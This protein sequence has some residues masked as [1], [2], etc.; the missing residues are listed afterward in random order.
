MTTLARLSCMILVLLPPISAQ[1]PS[2]TVLH[3]FGSGTDGNEPIAGVVIGPGG[4]L[5][6]TTQAGGT[7]HECPFLNC[8]T[9]F[10]L[11]PPATSGGAWT[12]T[13]LHNFVGYDGA[14]PEGGIAVGAGG[15]LYGTATYGGKFKAGT[16]F[17][18]TPPQAGNPG[19]EVWRF[20]LLYTFT[21]GADGA[22]PYAGVA[23]G[24]NGVLYGTTQNGGTAGQGTVFALIPP[25]P[26]TGAWT[27]TVIHNFTGGN[28][29]ASP[30]AG[31]AIGRGDVLYGTTQYGGPNTRCNAATPGCGTVFSMTPPATAGGTWNETVILNFDDYD[32]AV[33]QAGVTI[34]RHGE[35]YGIA[36]GFGANG[37][38][39]FTLTPPRSAGSSWTD[40]VLANVGAAS[41]SAAAVNR[42]GVIF[43]TTQFG[44]TSNQG[45]VFSLT[46]PA[47][48]G[49]T[50]T[51]TAIHNFGSD[52]SLPYAGVV[53]GRGG[54][55]YG[56][57]GF[58]GASGGGTVY[59]LG[60]GF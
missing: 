33:P 39:A 37:S 3:S 20:D 53:I 23:I 2:Y 40:T 31:L 58:G 59:A 43:G 38:I 28:D 51:Q 5:Y 11:T 17:S 7:G 16:V 54:V 14:I 25:K 10:S 6:G 1:S 4:V 36:T 34:G 29:G 18:L 22:N 24:S 55:L 30:V 32:G 44:G 50:W 56:T 41:T 35:L 47:S 27:E 26:A 48:P 12:E 45:V 46:P 42:S 19:G 9:V 21:G 15:V 13:I 57:T 49:G 8:G 52:G 60:P